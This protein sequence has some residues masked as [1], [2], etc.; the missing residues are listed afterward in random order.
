MNPVKG[1]AAALDG[2]IDVRTVSPSERAAKVNWLAVGPT[3]RH[4]MM[5]MV[6]D[7]HIDKTFA[8][9]QDKFPGLRII[10]VMVEPLQ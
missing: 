8:Q 5:H 9:Y 10:P 6:D 3:P 2:K 1:F 7:E 4:I